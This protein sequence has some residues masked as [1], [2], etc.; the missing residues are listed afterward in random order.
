MKLYPLLFLNEAQVFAS[1]AYKQGLVTIKVDIDGVIGLF[2]VNKNNIKDKATGELKESGQGI[3]YGGIQ[4]TDDPDSGYVQVKSSDAIDGYG[5]LLYQ[6]AMYSI[7]P[8]WLE[9]DESLSDDSY[10][11]WNKMYEFSEKGMYERTYIGNIGYSRSDCA[12]A[13]GEKPS[14]EEAADEESFLS[15]LQRLNI[16]PKEVG[17]Y[18]A[19]RKRSHEPEVAV[20]LKEGQKLFAEEMGNNEEKLFAWFRSAN[21]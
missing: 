6:I 5:P 20:M 4:Y 21:L 16:A 15:F 9:S 19:Y 17:C 10:R 18:W 12:N 13:L 7:K 1:Q 2:L 14:E 3:I 11:V 8:N